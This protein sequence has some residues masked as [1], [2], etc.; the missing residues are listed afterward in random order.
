MSIIDK[1]KKGRQ[2]VARDGLLI[3]D[4][5]FG[6]QYPGIFEMLVRVAYQGKPRQ[7]G[8]LVLYAEPNRA[9]CCLVDVDAGMVT[10]YTSETFG[11]A[12]LGM[13]KALQAG[14]CDWRKDKH[15]RS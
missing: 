3:G 4:D 1:I 13:E 6:E 8:R 5:S 15:R 12:L 9:T 7:P 14:S 2:E 11:D 10:F